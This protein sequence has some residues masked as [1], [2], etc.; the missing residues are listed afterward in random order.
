MSGENTTNDNNNIK[1]IK[2]IK[3]TN[4]TSGDELLAMEL[5]RSFY[6]FSDGG[7]TNKSTKATSGIQ[8]ESIDSVVLQELLSSIKE[9]VIPI[10]LQQLSNMTVPSI[11]EQ[12]EAG[13]LGTITVSLGETKVLDALV[14]QEN[15]HINV[16][17]TVI[18][19]IVKEISAKLKQFQWSYEKH[20]FPKMKDSGNADTTFSEA[21]I[22]LD[23]NIGLDGRSGK[24]SVTVSRCDVTIG[25]LDVKISGS[26]ASFI[27]NALL[28]VFK[29]TIKSSLE[30]SL[31]Q[32]ITNSVNDDPTLDFF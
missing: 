1:N 10:M 30:Q 15:I 19:I 8:L 28:A 2:N 5:S 25:R 9:G 4:D 22:I 3:N 13:K 17:K 11:N 20:T 31:S 16:D 32:L 23:M 29:R 18:K 12:I 14:P 7:E 26:L 24:P 27:Y 21:Q 6:S